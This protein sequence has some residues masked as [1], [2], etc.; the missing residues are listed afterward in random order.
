MISAN[1]Q[2]SSPYV[3]LEQMPDEVFAFQ[4]RLKE[5]LV[6]ACNWK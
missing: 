4:F 3:G 1:V 2:M 5:E 6:V